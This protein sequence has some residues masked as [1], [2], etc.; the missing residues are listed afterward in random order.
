MIISRNWIRSFIDRNDLKKK[1]PR[2]L[3]PN[4]LLKTISTVVN[5]W[6]DLLNPF[7]EAKKY[8][9]SLISNMDETM[10]SCKNKKVKVILPS[11]RR[12]GIKR[13]EKESEYITL[14]ITIF[15]DCTSAMPG[16][17]LEFFSI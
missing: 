14:I 10:L 15:A 17:I 12:T 8:H 11:E 6:F 7:L 16:V 13:L 5:E 4:Q 2:L 1:V 3:E 9:P